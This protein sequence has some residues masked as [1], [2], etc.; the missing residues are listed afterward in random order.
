MP[1]SVTAR[2]A[3]RG[4]TLPPPPALPPGVSIPFNWLRVHGRRVLVSGHGALTDAGAPAGPFGAV[5]TD[6]SIEEAQASACNALLSVL[7][8]ALRELDDLDRIAAWLS[9]TVFTN[10]AAGF[11]RLTLI[12]NPMSE[13]ILDLFGHDR[14][15]HARTAPGVAALPFHLPVIITAE[16]ALHP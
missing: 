4:L 10:A 12:A 3:K 1:T 15:A 6:V 16:L 11:D 14:G 13:L 8:S 5:P 7:A 2:L 9:V